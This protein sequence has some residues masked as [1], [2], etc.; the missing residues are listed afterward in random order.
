MVINKPAGLLVHRSAIDFHEAYNAQEIL[1]TQ[2]D[3]EVF[4]VHRLD[5][6]TSGV[7]LFAL[8]KKTAAAMAVKFQRHEVHKTYIAIVRGY[9]DD[10]GCVDNPVRDKDAP[11]KPRKP[12]VTHYKTLARIALPLPVDQFPEA[13]Y[14]MVQLEPESGRRHQLRQH[15]KHISHP[16][17]GDTSYGKTVHN[18]FFKQHLTCARLLLHA[19]SLRFTH[20]HSDKTISLTAS[21]DSQLRQVIDL[22]QWRRTSEVSS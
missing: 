13:R 17:I 9:A 19:R 3:H 7:L 2:I 12:A 15:M 6:P 22:P 21:Y 11:D 18:R 10:T 5:K 4:P 20:P 14:S 16:I 8:N 1:Q